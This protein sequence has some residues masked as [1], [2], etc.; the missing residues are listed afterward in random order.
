METKR[1]LGR[2][3]ERFNKYRDDSVS[4]LDSDLVTNRV[5]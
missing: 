2:E 3:L 1:S 5:L 4:G